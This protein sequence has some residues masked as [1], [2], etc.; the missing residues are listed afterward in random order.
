M[1]ICP[2]GAALFHANARAGKHDEGNVASPTFAN[3]PK[4]NIPISTHARTMQPRS[5][6]VSHTM[7]CVF[8]MLFNDFK[9]S[10]NS[11]YSAII[12]VASTKRDT[13][14]LTRKCSS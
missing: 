8:L 6:T 4:M 11:K 10:S 7:Y 9:N 14:R 1:K 5:Y 2:V 12:Y 13:S 3:A